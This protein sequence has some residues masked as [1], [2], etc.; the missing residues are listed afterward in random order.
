MLILHEGYISTCRPNIGRSVPTNLT[1]HSMKKIY[2]FC[3]LLLQYA[4][5]HAVHVTFRVDMTGQT[6][7]PAGVH[8]AGSFQGWNPSGT[9]LSDA[10]ADNI[11]EVTLDIAAN[12]TWQYKFLNGNFW[13]SDEGSGLG[14]CNSSGNRFFTTGSASEVRPVFCFNQC[15][16]CASNPQF[17]QVTFR[18]DMQNVMV[19]PNGVHLA[20]S[21]HFTP[22]PHTGPEWNPSG[23]AMTDAN[24]D[25]VYEVTLTLAEGY[26][27]QYKFINGNAWGAD[28]SVPGT[29]NVSGNRG[30]TC[31]TAA[32]TTLPEVCFA[33]CSDCIP[34]PN[35]V[36]VIF[37]VD[38]SNT[39]TI[40]PLGVHLAGS[41]GANG[42]PDWNP[43]GIAMSDANADMI[44]EATLL[45]TEGLEYQYKFINGNAWGS[46]E[47][48]PGACNVGGNRSVTAP[49]TNLTIPV[50]CFGTCAAC[51]PPPPTA[52]VTF[53][54]NMG[55][56]PISS[57]GVHL[58]G[59]FGSNGYP[60]WNPGGLQMTDPDGDNIYQITLNLYLGWTYNYKFVNGNA[61]GSDESV[62]G[63]CAVGFD[64][65]VV[66]SGA[67]STPVVCFASCSA[68][69]A[70]PVND[71]RSGAPNMVVYNFGTCLS[72]SGDLTLAT[73]SSE[74]NSFCPT[75]GHD[76]WHR[77]TAGSPGIRVVVASAADILIEL[78][79]A[80]GNTLA[81]EN[82]VTGAGTEILNYY[83]SPALV[84]GQVYFIA[85]R[86][87]NLN[88]GTG[89]YTIC[90]QRIA[91]PVCNSSA[92]FTTCGNF[93]SS[94]V[95]ASSY[96]FNF[97][98]QSTLQS[99]VLTS[100]NGITIIP[101][102]SLVP[103]A[104][105][106]VQITANFTLLNG[107]GTA[108]PSTITGPPCVITMAANPDVFLRTADQC[109]AGPRPANAIVAANRWVCGASHYEWR[110]RQVAPLLDVA[111]GTP[112]AGAPTNRFLNLM[113]V[114][115]VPG[116][117]YEVQVRPVFPGGVMGSWGTTTCLQLIGSLSAEGDQ[118][119]AAGLRSAVEASEVARWSIYPN[120]SAGDALTI[121]WMEG[122]AADVQIRVM[123]GTGRVVAA[124]RSIV[125][126]GSAI[127]MEFAEP[128]ASGVYLVELTSGGKSSTSRWM[129]Q[130]H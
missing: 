68:C 86:N 98:N 73:P 41:F 54:V 89:P 24:A 13:G 82:A 18:V 96:T 14:S 42:Y 4:T 109:S 63:A 45:L 32:S 9:P 55:L 49:A 88:A 28:E 37:R 7:H 20:G 101:L 34:I 78:Q 77:F 74:A 57:N 44:Y 66:V 12:T 108:E 128:L 91:A 75:G 69:P 33:S 122:D 124:S 36:E 99:T 30:L 26:S 5:A 48:V 90:L 23:I 93:K 16:F 118:E 67:A 38:M 81:T 19:S 76:L 127:P 21:F 60:E 52:P 15:S 64:R 62:P 79:D 1:D 123:D 100:T 125:N 102:L 61:W 10:N 104:T 27:Y 103:G 107:S 47:N 43:G 106:S 120:P 29:C 84:I 117:Q 6:V 65:Q 50:V 112:V 97:V 130:R 31:P 95:G 25:E 87:F 39:A 40:S 35:T 70:G 2:L 11:W 22:A 115:L 85:V 94:N 119:P 114:G 59:S 129:V 53:R 83:P 58:A 51:I 8:I 72:Q 92:P 56:Q 126:A 46:D 121:R 110:F 80:A 113:P 17:R 3:A 116:A 111:F 105:Y 71:S